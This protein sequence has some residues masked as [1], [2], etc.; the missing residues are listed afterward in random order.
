MERLL[1][2]HII[3][4]LEANHIP[5]DIQFGFH[6]SQSTEVQLLV[7]Y[8][9]INKLVDAGILVDLVLLNF[10]KPFDVV[11]HHILLAQLAAV[12]IPR[13]LVMWIEN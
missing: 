13:L 11:C 2:T 4:H 8:A 3:D 10:S 12:G 5:S 1:A 6:R 9:S 7:T